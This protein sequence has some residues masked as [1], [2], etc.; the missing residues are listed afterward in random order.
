[1]YRPAS[2]SAHDTNALVRQV[3]IALIL[4][5]GSCSSC[6]EEKPP[7]VRPAAEASTEAS[8]G[9]P[10]DAAVAAASAP[11]DS[12]ASAP[13]PDAPWALV[14]KRKAS[15]HPLWI[16]DVGTRVVVG[17]RSPLAWADG[18]GPLA[19]APTKIEAD[20]VSS[21]AG[22]FPSAM[23]VLTDKR[24]HQLVGEGYRDLGPIP[25][26]TRTMVTFGAHG[27]VLVSSVIVGNAMPTISPDEYPATK[28]KAFLADGEVAPAFDLDPAFG[29]FAASG[30]RDGHLWLL[31]FRNKKPGMW[32]AHVKPGQ[33]TGYQ[34]YP[35]SEK[36]DEAGFGI[37]VYR[38]TVI[39]ISGDRAFLFVV[40][41]AAECMGPIGTYLYERSD[42]G[43]G[44][45]ALPKSGIDAMGTHV[46]GSAMDGTL[47]LSTLDGTAWRRAPDG[48][49]T[50]L[51]VPKTCGVTEIVVRDDG[52]AWMTARC[53]GHDGVYRRGR[54]QEPLA[55]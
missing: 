51:D 8:A 24:V 39:G 55:L 38:S 20:Y 52:D 46:I 1:V 3:A 13:S 30:T 54:P 31:G 10:L 34:L 42:K 9:A 43:F 17:D 47:Y 22:T 26:D 50:R 32:L 40:N 21:V 5:C 7:A 49:T 44:G 27:A 11:A 15:D 36:C 4:M 53:E 48:K 37:Y 19:L 29:T 18:K 33:K 12:D 25:R 45:L 6:R 41:D 14:A 28:L 23:F 16:A 2:N 35:G